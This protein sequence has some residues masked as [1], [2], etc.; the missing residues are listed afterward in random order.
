MTIAIYA[1]LLVLA[2]LTS[3]IA[4]VDV[5]TQTIPDLASAGLGLAG[6]VSQGQI[7]TI[8]TIVVSAASYF[9]IFWAIR[10]AHWFATRRVGLGFG[11]VK[12]AGAAGTWLSVGLFPFFIGVAAFTAL[13]A[14]AVAAL[15]KGKPLLSQRI[16][17]APFMAISLVTCWILQTSSIDLVDLYD[18]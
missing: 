8:P 14:V 1:E 7:A 6:L 3:T 17:F 16:P 13:L 2:A 5:R 12:L 11:D 10:S 4:V 9:L 18:F 15:V